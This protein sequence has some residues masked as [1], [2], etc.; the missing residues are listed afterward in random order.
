ML[1][2]RDTIMYRSHGAQWLLHDCCCLHAPTCNTCYKKKSLAHPSRSCVHTLDRGQTFVIVMPGEI[3]KDRSLMQ[4]LMSDIALL[5]G[6]GIH[7]VLVVGT[8]PQI[9]EALL[10]NG[11]S[12]VYVGGYRCAWHCLST[13]A[14]CIVLQTRVLP[15]ASASC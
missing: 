11:V 7:L 4:S 12:P 5:H 13:T 15:A 1:H 6:L 2:H 8:Q 9:D 3:V 14:H 10:N